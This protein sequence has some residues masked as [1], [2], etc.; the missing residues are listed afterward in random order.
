MTMT[1]ALA[2]GPPVRSEDLYRRALAAYDAVRAAAAGYDDPDLG[3]AISCYLG[4]GRLVT[5]LAAAPWIVG[6][7]AVEEAERLIS[8]APLCNRCEALVEW[9]EVFPV[10]LL[11]VLD[12]R[13][14]QTRPR[15]GG[16]RAWDRASDR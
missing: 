8:S 10:R 2:S 3:L 11:A 16:R 9:L 5:R 1:A 14:R 7:T 12:R 4:R 15:P 13:Q 6:A